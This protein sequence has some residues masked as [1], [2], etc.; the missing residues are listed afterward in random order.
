MTIQREKETTLT[1]PGMKTQISS[2]SNSAFGLDNGI[3]LTVRQNKMRALA[4]SS[5]ARA[6]VP[7]NP[8]L[9]RRR[10]EDM[11]KVISA[12]S[13][14]AFQRFKQ[15]TWLDAVLQLPFNVYDNDH[16]LALA[17]K[18]LPAEKIHSKAEVEDVLEEM[19]KYHDLYI[20]EVWNR[21]KIL[22]RAAKAAAAAPSRSTSSPEPSDATEREGKFIT[23]KVVEG[24]YRYP[25][26]FQR[27]DPGPDAAMDFLISD[28]KAKVGE[29]FAP[30]WY[31]AKLATML[32]W[33][34]DVYLIEAHSL[35]DRKG[36]T[37]DTVRR[38][39]DN[40][41]Y[42]DLPEVLASEPD[43]PYAVFGA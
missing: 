10:R 36:K 39:W 27:D 42:L 14:S 37:V 34:V 19:C 21:R 18:H 17:R 16:L 30:P 26:F 5:P 9:E 35:L 6:T 24:L 31:N 33:V 13:D 38:S 23:M 4:V 20:A 3:D 29:L 8:I 41:K 2:G 12:L 32:R 22:R 1:H 43:L 40:Y 15:A 25:P 11:R 28:K 7:V